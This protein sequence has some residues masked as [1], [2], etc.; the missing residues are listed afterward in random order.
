MDDIKNQHGDHNPKI[1]SLD[2]L[3]K[4]LEDKIHPIRNFKVKIPREEIEIYIDKEIERLVHTFT[5]IA[6]DLGKMYKRY[7]NLFI[8]SYVSRHVMSFRELIDL[9]N[10]VRDK[11]DTKLEEL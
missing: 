3:T 11:D 10:A 2:D 7:E 8:L 6:I 9:I 5:N 4:E 1:K